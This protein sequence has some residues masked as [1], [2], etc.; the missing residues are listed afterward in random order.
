MRE[1]QEF[2]YPDDEAIST[3]AG[4]AVLLVLHFVGVTQR[5]YIVTQ[6]RSIY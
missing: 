2:A 4:T 6:N 3:V 5:K 1:M